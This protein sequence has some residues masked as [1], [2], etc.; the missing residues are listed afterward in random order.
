MLCAPS[1][2][3]VPGHLVMCLAPKRKHNPH[4]KRLVYKKTF[5]PALKCGSVIARNLQK[6]K[7]T[8][9]KTIQTSERYR[10][11]GG[12]GLGPWR[13]RPDINPPFQKGFFLQFLSV[14]CSLEMLP[15]EHFHCFLFGLFQLNILN[16]WYVY[17]IQ[18]FFFLKSKRLYSEVSPCVSTTPLLCPTR[19]W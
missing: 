9:G 11:W 19:W 18:I 2:P 6:P 16:H 14:R 15:Q 7:S 3:S 1:P 4:S 8:H 10:I 5:Y 12:E 13:N 17:G